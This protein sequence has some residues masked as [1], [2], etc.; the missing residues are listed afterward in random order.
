MS[1]PPP[2]TD[3]ESQLNGPRNPNNGLM[4]T[5]A[6]FYFSLPA[7]ILLTVIKEMKS[8]QKGHRFGSLSSRLGWVMQ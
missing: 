7:S 4:N 8:T 2:P 3:S 5:E 6:M 1:M